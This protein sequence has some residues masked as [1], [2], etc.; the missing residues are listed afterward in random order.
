MKLFIVLAGLCVICSAAFAQQSARP[1]SPPET[2][3]GK[4]G[5]ATIMIKY[6]APSVRGRQIFGEGG[7]VSHDKQAPIWRAGANEATALHTDAN[8]RIGGLEVPKGDYTLFV[9]LQDPNAW[10]LIISKKTGEWGLNYDPSQDLGRVK[11]QM[12]KPPA[13]VETL[14]YTITNSGG[15]RGTIELAWEKQ[16]ASVPVVAK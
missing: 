4:I 3:T 7:L 13:P 5:D 1:M 11:M 2:A 9:N 14:K 15:G 16:A 12:S 10:E 8:I 6:S